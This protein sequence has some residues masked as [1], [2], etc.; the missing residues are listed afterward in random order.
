MPAVAQ[1]VPLGNDR[2]RLPSP[3]IPVE[4]ESEPLALFSSGT[5]FDLP[6]MYSDRP[7][8]LVYHN[9]Y[10][11]V[12]DDPALAMIRFGRNHTT[13]LIDVD[14]DQ[15]VDVLLRQWPG[16]AITAQELSELARLRE[17]NQIFEE[18]ASLTDLFDCITGMS[19][20]GDD[21]LGGYPI[22]DILSDFE[23]PVCDGDFSSYVAQRTRS[24]RSVWEQFAFRTPHQ[25]AAPKLGV[26]SERGLNQV[27]A[28][29]RQMI[30][31]TGI[32]LNDALE[33]GDNRAARLLTNLGEAYVRLQQIVGEYRSSGRT[34]GQKELNEAY[35]DYEQARDA[36]INAAS[37]SGEPVEDP[38]RGA[39][40]PFEDPRCIGRR[41]DASRGTLFTDRR[42][43]TD[44]NYLAC[45]ERAESALFSATGGQ[46]RKTMGPDDRV[47]IECSEPDEPIRRPD[48]ESTQPRTDGPDV[49]DPNAPLVRGRSNQE[50]LLNSKLGRR[51]EELCLRGGGLCP[52]DFRN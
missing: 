22:A 52:E 25:T 21:A 46:C 18:G 12:G 32:L 49:S 13:I 19:S 8:D 14:I 10:F 27:E 24:R 7:A 38:T 29:L 48:G 2:V 47:R 42:F 37:D 11:S 36:W 50:F 44:R 43:C 34:E 3:D 30:R 23:N 40:H 39:I 20:G 5:P 35:A 6:S 17:C 41:I 45:L 9:L 31:T 4:L 26:Y 51:L 15:E 1:D 28:S 16:G 33:Q